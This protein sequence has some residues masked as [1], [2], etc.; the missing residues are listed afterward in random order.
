MS[1]VPVTAEQFTSLPHERA[2]LHAMIAVEFGDF[3]EQV[4]RDNL[5]ALENGLHIV[6]AYLNPN[7]REGDGTAKVKTYP[8]GT[9]VLRVRVFGHAIQSYTRS[10]VILAR[11]AARVRSDDDMLDRVNKATEAAVAK[12]ATLDND[13][14]RAWVTSE[15]AHLD[16]PTAALLDVDGFG[17]AQGKGAVDKGYSTRIREQGTRI[18]K[19]R[20]EHAYTEQTAY[21]SEDDMIDSLTADW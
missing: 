17:W 1:A 9:S 11:L 8:V 15:K 5:H 21:L 7:G 4:A 19:N 14:W 16:G 2:N 3:A 18:A 13:L 6:D 12:L 20:S 10:V